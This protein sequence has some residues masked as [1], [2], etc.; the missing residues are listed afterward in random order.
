MIQSENLAIFE[1]KSKVSKTRDAMPTKIGLH[2][3]LYLHEL[4]LFFDPHG[5]YGP[6]ES[7]NENK[8]EQN[9]QN[10]RGHDSELAVYA[11]LINLYL[12]E[13][14][15][16]ILFLTPWTVVHGLQGN[17]EGVEKGAKSPKL[18][19]SCYKTRLRHFGQKY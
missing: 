4:I 12:H 14:F 2:I 19:N 18:E 13:F 17:F 7:L 11:Y 10:Q 8:K 5:Q 3:N 6:K 16:P 1:K 9:F 15:E